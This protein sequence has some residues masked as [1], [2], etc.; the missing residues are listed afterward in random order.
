MVREIPASRIIS[1]LNV[2]VVVLQGDGTVAS[3]NPA[4]AQILGLD[5]AEA[6]GKPLAQVLPEH[7]SNQPL[8]SLARDLVQSGQE[9]DQSEAEST[10]IRAASPGNFWSRAGPRGARAGSWSWRT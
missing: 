1:A 8:L 7:D 2:G 3:L 10:I 4:A 9:L 5:A 6:Q